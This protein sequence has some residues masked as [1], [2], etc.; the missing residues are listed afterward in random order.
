MLFRAQKYRRIWGRV[1]VII[2]EDDHHLLILPEYEIWICFCFCVCVCCV[3]EILTKM[4]GVIPRKKL[5]K[6]KKFYTG[7]VWVTQKEE[8]GF[9][10]R[11]GRWIWGRQL[12]RYMSSSTLSG[13]IPRVERCSRA[14]R[15]L[16]YV[17]QK[18]KKKTHPVLFMEFCRAKSIYL[19]A[20][21]F[22]F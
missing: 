19:R 20:K 18:E 21:E 15:G 9:I 4:C 6:P 12:E 14:L 5:K 8:M 10:E 11:R 3:C 16:S 13:Q 17:I 22:P 1:V 7:E 2:A